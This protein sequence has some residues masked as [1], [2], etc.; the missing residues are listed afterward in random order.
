MLS[1]GVYKD[2]PSSEASCAP[3]FHKQVASASPHTC[4][5]RGSPSCHSSVPLHFQCNK[6]LLRSL[7][8]MPVFL[9]QGDVKLTTPAAARLKLYFRYKLCLSEG[10]TVDRPEISHLPKIS[11]LLLFSLSSPRLYTC[12]VLQDKGGLLLSILVKGRNPGD[13]DWAPASIS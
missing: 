12:A 13:N 2:G 4:P 9:L 6:P 3:P 10:A 1:M 5:T 7:E 11:Y 8:T